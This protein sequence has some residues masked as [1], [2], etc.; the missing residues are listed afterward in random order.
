MASRDKSGK[1]RAISVRQDLSYGADGNGEKPA[2]KFIAELPFS[3]RLAGGRR[4]TVTV[5]EPG[6]KSG[7]IITLDPLWQVFWPLKN[8]T[9]RARLYYK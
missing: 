2:Q 9:A 6:G 1:K 4:I 8:R 5:T 3:L 7:A